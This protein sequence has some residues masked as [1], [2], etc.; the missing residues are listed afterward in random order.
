[1]R[2]KSSIFVG[3]LAVTLQAVPCAAQGASTSK[4]TVPQAD[5]A[6]S[7][8]GRVGSLSPGE[9]K[10]AAR[11]RQRA[12]SKATPAPA[13]HAAKATTASPPPPA[14]TAE[15]PPS[16]TTRVTA[17]RPESPAP[18]RKAEQPRRAVPIETAER[19]PRPIPVHHTVHARRKVETRIATQPA[20]P[21]RPRQA[22]RRYA[23]AGRD[24][25]FPRRPFL[26]GYPGY[27]PRYAM[28]DGSVVYPRRRFWRFYARARFM[29][30]RDRYVT[31]YGAPLYVVPQQF[32][33]PPGYSYA[34][35]GAFGQ[36]EVDE[37]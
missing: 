9:A 24:V 17:E 22:E 20:L 36:S 8:P 31:S 15:R 10:R 5:K 29:Y 25:R 34:G 28:S 13:V 23:D 6:A 35:T 21:S 7:D 4:D 16:T 19:L 3:V 2:V 12:A 26:R 33:P 32:G 1:M 11:A 27:V 14:R 18:V 37:Q 30:P